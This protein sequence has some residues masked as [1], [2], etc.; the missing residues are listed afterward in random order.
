ML[1]QLKIETGRCQHHDGLCVNCNL[2]EAMRGGNVESA[3][4]ILEA[5]GDPNTPF[6]ADYWNSPLHVAA[7]GEDIRPGSNK[8]KI[9]ELL[10]SHGADI[11]VVNEDGQTPLHC[12]V[13]NCKPGLV[14]CL[15]A[16][17]ADV[18]KEQYD[19]NT[20]MSLLRVSDIGNI[21]NKMRIKRM[22]REQTG[23][24]G[25]GEDVPVLAYFLIPLFLVGIGLIACDPGGWRWLWIII[26]GLFSLPGFG[27]S[28]KSLTWLKKNRGS[29][30]RKEIE[31]YLARADLLPHSASKKFR[32]LYN[33]ACDLFTN[34][35][36]QAAEGGF[37]K[38]LQA[39]GTSRFERMI[40]AYARAKASEARGGFV[41]IPREF[42]DNPEVCGNVF[43]AV[44]VAC[45]LVQ[46]GHKA[47]AWGEDEWNV[48]TQVEGNLYHLTFSSLFGAFMNSGEWLH[49][50][51][52]TGLGEAAEA[53][54]SGSP[55]AYVLGLFQDVTQHGAPVGFPEVKYTRDSTH[56][57]SCGNAMST[58][59]QCRKCNLNFCPDCIVAPTGTPTIREFETHGGGANR[60]GQIHIFDT[61]DD[62]SRPTCPRCGMT[63]G[64]TPEECCA[65]ASGRIDA[66]AATN[67]YKEASRLSAQ[68][69]HDEALYILEQL[70]AT[71]P[72]QKN[73]LYARAMTLASLG[74]IR[75]ARSLCTNLI[76][77]FGDTRAQKLLQE[78]E[79]S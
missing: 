73:I 62:G 23:S 49:D 51:K 11:D 31:A 29:K 37:T 26:G 19:G 69:R 45:H 22:L 25:D 53:A 47:V 55:H 15:L 54:G 16:H 57:T 56:C 28:I 27:K 71:Y 1:R 17:G 5:G 39:G 8:E 58:V 2:H 59:W 72:N 33:D 63:L 46:D 10:L 68:K 43:V 32:H 70:D 41:D 9:I 3:I 50:S 20:P 12:A 21:A 64:T 42:H 65:R 18:N 52:S 66:V 4:A 7:C 76:A 78:L 38:A 13:I 35:K 75:E 6:P 60:R 40:A 14:A 24:F 74:R 77:T 36:H 79:N 61:T 67:M 44:T 48:A 30:E 34:G